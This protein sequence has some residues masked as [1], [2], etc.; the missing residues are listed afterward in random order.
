MC[1]RDSLS[2]A[3]LLRAAASAR[4]VQR[5][6][7]SSVEP[8][9]FPVGVLAEE[10]GS[11]LCEHFHLPLQSGSDRL[12]A[13]MRRPYRA[14]GYAAVVEGVVRA[15][16]GAAVGADVM[17]GFPGETDQDHRDTLALVSSLPVAYLHVFAFS[18][19]PGTRAAAMDG[20][21]PP[22]V[23]VRRA[24]E[25]RELSARRWAS[26][27]EGLRG[28]ELE[29]AV[30]RLRGA[31]ASGTSREYALVRLPARGAVRGALRRVRVGDEGVSLDSKV[32]RAVA[33][34]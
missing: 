5:I 12:L 21:V 23:A 26:F 32:A 33:P 3:D 10:A 16:P 4:S 15:R 29:V 2:L 31:E 30:E 27:Q 22:E 19:R 14:A 11:I 6:R 1:I 7:L 8:V 20:R 18:P 28:R 34:S 24:A 25:L 9:E 13:A 17:T